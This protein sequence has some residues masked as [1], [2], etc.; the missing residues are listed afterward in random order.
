[1]HG[2]PSGCHR[3]LPLKPLDDNVA[4]VITSTS[5][6]TTPTEAPQTTTFVNVFILTPATAQN[7]CAQSWRL[8]FAST[9]ALRLLRAVLRPFENAGDARES[10]L[11]ARG[12]SEQNTAPNVLACEYF[13]VGLLVDREVLSPY[14][15]R[16]WQLGDGLASYAGHNVRYVDENAG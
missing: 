7:M 1:M 13:A 10:A 12:L 16:S 5:K 3:P 14:T 8:L 6:I 9:K 15:Y 4:K 2:W 11:M